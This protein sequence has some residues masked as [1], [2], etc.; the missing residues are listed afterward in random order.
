MELLTCTMVPKQVHQKDAAPP[1]R[2]TEMPNS[3]AVV[4]I[5]SLFG[6]SFFNLDL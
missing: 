4:Y 3:E 2:S 1:G 6:L 5:Q